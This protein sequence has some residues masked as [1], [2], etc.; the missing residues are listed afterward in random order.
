MTF[1]PFVDR[2]DGPERPCYYSPMHSPTHTR[3]AWAD[4]ARSPVPLPFQKVPNPPIR[5]SKPSQDRPTQ[6]HTPHTKRNKMEHFGT[7]FRPQTPTPATPHPRRKAAAAHQPAP[8]AHVRRTSRRLP[9]VTN[10]R[11]TPK[12]PT[13][14]SCHGGCRP[15]ARH[16]ASRAQPRHRNHIK[17]RAHQMALPRLS[18]AIHYQEVQKLILS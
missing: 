2:L 1:V 8:T 17:T 5:V 9:R 3:R 18:A 14:A 11:F 7:L 12:S 13:P 4:R 16:S 6:S 10:A 15:P